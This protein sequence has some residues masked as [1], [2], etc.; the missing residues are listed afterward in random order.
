MCKVNPIYPA[1]QVNN[2][3]KHSSTDNFQNILESEL[4][5]DHDQV[6]DAKTNEIVCDLDNLGDN[7]EALNKLLEE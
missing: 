7:K 5:I 2:N 1:A 6:Y 4:D 3:L